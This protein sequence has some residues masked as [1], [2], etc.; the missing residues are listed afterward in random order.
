[1]VVSTEAKRALDFN[2]QGLFTEE[3]KNNFEMFLDSLEFEL[4][5]MRMTEG[6]GFANNKLYI[7]LKKCNDIDRRLGMKGEFTLI[8]LLH[9]IGHMLRLTTNNNKLC[10]YLNNINDFDSYYET[11]LDEEEF[12]E[13]YSEEKFEMLL[14]RKLP[15]IIKRS[16]VDINDESYKNQM[17]NVFTTKQELGS[18][19][20]YINENRLKEKEDYSWVLIKEHQ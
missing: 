5:P 20:R 18:W 12:T 13:I 2:L 8:V 4:E 6:I 11:I 9:E 17:R 3:Q 16:I 7:D 19:E 1:M 10:N 15:Y 14:G